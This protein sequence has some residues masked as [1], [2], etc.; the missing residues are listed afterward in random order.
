LGTTT[1]TTTTTTRWPSS[2]AKDTSASSCLR[3]VCRS[4][5]YACTCCTSKRQFCFLEVVVWSLKTS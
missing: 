1:T 3:Y 4:L 2:S 5:S